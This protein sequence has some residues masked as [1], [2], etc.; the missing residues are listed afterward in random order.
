MGAGTDAEGPF[1]FR[2]PFI[3]PYVPISG[4]RLSDW[5]HLDSR[6]GPS[7]APLGVRKLGGPRPRPDRHAD[8]PLYYVRRR[9]VASVRALAKARCNAITAMCMRM[10]KPYGGGL[11]DTTEGGMRADYDAVETRVA[12]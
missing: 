11:V 1:C 7:L 5:L 8:G 3:K 4:I 9:N 10:S 12:I 2:S 6:R